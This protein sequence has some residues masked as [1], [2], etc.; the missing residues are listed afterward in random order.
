[1]LEQEVARGHLHP[2]M[3]RKG[4]RHFEVRASDKPRTD[5]TV[6]CRDLARSAEDEKPFEFSQSTKI[7]RDIVPRMQASSSKLD[8]AHR[9]RKDRGL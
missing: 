1:M 3:E 7:R 8:R 2:F 9:E 6:V 5:S 4:H